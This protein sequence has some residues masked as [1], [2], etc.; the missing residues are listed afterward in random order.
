MLV[1]TVLAQFIGKFFTLLEASNFVVKT[2]AGNDQNQLDV[3]IGQAGPHYQNHQQTDVYAI[4]RLES[5]RALKLSNLTVVLRTP[6][7]SILESFRALKHSNLGT[8]SVRALLRI[9]SALGNNW[10]DWV[11][12]NSK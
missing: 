4:T 6:K 2:K 1:S 11:E 3:S 9:T 5:F 8:A 7:L 10:L 12:K